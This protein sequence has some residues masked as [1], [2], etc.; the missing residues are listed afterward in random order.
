[1]TNRRRIARLFAL[2]LTTH[3]SASCLRPVE[4]HPPVLATNALPFS[5]RTGVWEWEWPRPHG[6]GLNAVW[7]S[8][9][10]EA[11]AV[12]HGGTIVHFE[13]DRETVVRSGTSESLRAVWGAARN[14]IWAVGPRGTILHF[15]GRAWT[16]S[17]SPVEDDLSSVWGSGP[18]DVWAVGET[19][20]STGA[21]GTGTILHWDGVRWSVVAR[22]VDPAFEAVWGS[23]PRDVF[24]GGAG[25]LWRFDGATWSSQSLGSLE[26]R[27]IWGTGPRDI[28][29]AGHGHGPAH[30][31]GQQWQL[32]DRSNARSIE[33]LSGDGRG[34]VW[35][36]SWDG[37]LRLRDGEWVKSAVPFDERWSAVGGRPGGP[38]WLVGAL[39]GARVWNGQWRLVH[40]AYPMSARALWPQRGGRLFVVDRDG[41]LYQHTPQ[42]WQ[43][44][45][46][47]PG[48]EPVPRAYATWGT[49][50]ALWIGISKGAARWDGRRW[51][52][53]ASRGLPL[54][55]MSGNA[56]NEIWGMAESQRRVWTAVL[57]TWDGQRWEEREA[58]RWYFA[59][60]GTSLDDIWLVG[61]TVAHW[62][63]HAFRDFG[64]LAETGEP[65][66]ACAN[67]RDDVWFVGQEGLILHWDG[68]AFRRFSVPGAGH[69]ERIRCHGPDDVWATGGHGKVLAWDGRAWRSTSAP[70]IPVI[71]VQPDGADLFALGREGELLRLQ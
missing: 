16:P 42:G 21:L 23:G 36:T 64:R 28:W 25:P 13:G 10:T 63:G 3:T 69:L 61:D 17:T 58:P 38:V 70:C 44:S 31:D 18:R 7:V 24:V 60:A 59:T 52:I 32:P 30:W 41:A 22:N 46:A 11:W 53:H 39:G 67:G 55:T 66:A 4:K 47:P 65:R 15:D 14:D 50:D 48:D 34:R 5:Q 54:Y 56:S 6:H 8:S 71:D 20:S 40:G 49:R 26:T 45:A 29:V 62:D 68:R 37:V 2:A 12:G 1:M 57:R 27:T 35:G 19:R 43:R 51:T 9:T 33:S